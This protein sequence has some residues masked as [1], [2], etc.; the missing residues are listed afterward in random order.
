[1]SLTMWNVRLVFQCRPIT[2]VVFGVLLIVGC[3]EKNAGPQQAVPSTT[4]QLA[5]ASQSEWGG[6][7]VEFAGANWE[8]ASKVVILMHGYGASGSD[9][10]PLSNVLNYDKSVAFVFPQA[11]IEIGHE[12]FAWSHRNDDG[13]IRSLEQVNSLIKQILDR[14]PNCQIV[15]GGFSQGGTMACNLLATD[16]PSI[17]GAMLFSPKPLL[18]Q[19]PENKTRQSKVFIVHGSHDRMIPFSDV[20]QLKNDL[21]T[22]GFQVSWH[23]FG[24][25]HEITMRSLEQA[26]Q[27]L[28]E[29]F[30][31][32]ASS[33][34]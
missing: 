20:E 15:V 3:S 24:G 2:V 22:N 31:E 7:K 10:V 26:Y 16:H 14:N 12:S 17:V 29:A 4:V 21:E 11:P 6:L 8:K 19:T 1:M 5:P 28:S 25:D 18:L 13:F 30:A 34:Q 27:F 33:D 23:P 9:L 32:K